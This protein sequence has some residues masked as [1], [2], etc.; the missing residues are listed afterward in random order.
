MADFVGE[1]T[2]ASAAHGCSSARVT[3]TIHAVTRCKAQNTQRVEPATAAAD[4]LKAQ[5]IGLQ[6][7]SATP[8]WK[9]PAD[10]R[11]TGYEEIAVDMTSIP[12]CVA[13][14]NLALGL[15]TQH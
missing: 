4:S 15:S 13:G 14:R 11:N 1:I 10:P 9:R 2:D 8:G 7:A 12:R 6:V 5:E 3:H